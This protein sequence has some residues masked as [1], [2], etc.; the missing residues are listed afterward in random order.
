[1]VPLL[2]GPAHGPERKPAVSV[3]LLGRRP[4]A[5]ARRLRADLPGRQHRRRDARRGARPGA[6]A[7]RYVFASPRRRARATRCCSCQEDSRVYGLYA[8]GEAAAVRARSSP[9]L[10]EMARSLSL[11]RPAAYPEQRERRP[12]ASR[13]ACRL[14]E[15]RRARFSGGG[16]LPHAVH[17]PAVGADKSGQ[18]VHA[19]LTLTV[20]PAP[21]DGSLDAFYKAT[22]RRSWARPSSSLSHAPWKDGYVDVAALGDARRGSRGEALLP[23]R[24]GRGYTLAFEARDDV[25]PRVSR[26]CDLIAGDAAGRARRWQRSERP[27]CQRI[28]S[29]LGRLLHG[30]DRLELT[31][32]PGGPAGRPARPARRRRASGRSRTVQGR[33]CLTPDEASYYLYFVLPAEFLARAPARAL[34]GGRVLRRPL[35]AVPRAVRLDATARAECD[36]LYKPAEQ[37]WDGDAA[38]PA[39][40]PARAL[41]AA[42]LRS[43]A[44]AEPGR[45]LP[46]R[47]PPRGADRA[48]GGRR[49]EPPADAAAFPRVAP[50][51]ELKKLPGPLL[52]DQL[53]LHRDH[54]RLQLQVHVVPGRHHGPRAAGFMKKEKA[55]RLLDEIAA[56]RS[57]LGP[58]YPV[59]L[60][61]MGEP[62]LH[63]DLLA[64][65]EHAESRGV[66]IELN[67]NCGLITRREHR[68]PL[69]RRPDQPD[70]VLPDARRR[71]ASRRAR[72][73]ASPSTTTATRCAWPWSARSPSARAPTSRSTS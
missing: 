59:K 3:T 68:R 64:I 26:W 30:P 8:Q 33:P 73:R 14:L 34:A 20:E 23:R 15:R 37:R 66:G 46:R 54:Q 60:H 12:S 49:C 56:K 9:A 50:L 58:L 18:T 47:V 67:T 48:R 25:Y 16:T 69:P 6:A 21:G 1:M 29:A 7:S 53:P 10:D 39:P 36:G 27:R 70:P 31:V 45:V 61:Q 17:E 40:L 51:P 13:S 57:W 63:P 42:R 22:P 28:G 65:V 62:F 72:R 38:G 41:P 19:S 4:W 2:P 11:E 32:G 52:P 44:H 5:D 24:G 43:G 55:F 35:R 71:D